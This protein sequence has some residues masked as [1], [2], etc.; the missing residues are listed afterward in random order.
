MRM[1]PNL[2]LPPLGPLQMARWVALSADTRALVEAGAAFVWVWAS[3]AEASRAREA[4]AQTWPTRVSQ[5]PPQWLGHRA[6]G[7]VVSPVSFRMLPANS[8]SGRDT[9]SRETAPALLPQGL[10]GGFRSFLPRTRKLRL[11]G[12]EPVA[13]RVRAGVRTQALTLCRPS[14]P[15]TSPVS[16]LLALRWHPRVGGLDGQLPRLGPAPP[17]LGQ[18]S[19]ESVTHNGDPSAEDCGQKCWTGQWDPRGRNWR[20]G[21]SPGQA[22]GHPCKCWCGRLLPPISS[23]PQAAPGGL[24]NSRKHRTQWRLARAAPDTGHPP[25]DPARPPPALAVENIG[26]HPST[27][28]GVT[29]YLCPSAGPIGTYLRYVPLLN[30][31]AKAA[32]GACMVGSGPQLWPGGSDIVTLTRIDA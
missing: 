17:P 20:A 4:S 9:G 13:S 28:P 3:H 26:G 7:L 24:S 11:R 14:P 6:G 27:G 2:F 23:P 21:S 19:L 10:R 5:R 15:S 31:G 8:G 29:P 16:L 32:Q 25:P 18:T 30:K 12:A 22:E 1:L